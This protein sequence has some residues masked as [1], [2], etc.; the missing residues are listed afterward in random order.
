MLHG[1][2]C[3]FLPGL[4]YGLCGDSGSGKTSLLRLLTLEHEATGG[5]ILFDKKKLESV[6]PDDICRVVGYL[7]QDY[8]DLETYSVKDA[9]ELSGR[10]GETTIPLSQAAG[11]A[12][13]TFAGDVSTFGEK[14]I[15]TAVKGGRPFSGGERHRIAMARVLFKDSRVLILDEPTSSLGILT[16]KAILRSVRELAKEKGLTVIIVSHRYSNLKSADRILF[17]DNG[18][19]V[20][21]GSHKKLMALGGRYAARYTLEKE[22]YDE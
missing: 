14:R 12:Q 10:D 7:P 20:E 17:F 4:V 15:G 13:V 6:S 18:R 22:G 16:E 8:L 2:T 3:T 21:R 9:V 11:A 1:I 19:I 5:Q